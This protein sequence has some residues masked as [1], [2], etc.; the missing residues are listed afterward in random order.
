M[1]K[2]HKELKWI[3]KKILR[4][5]LPEDIIAQQKQGFT[6][7]LKIW[8]RTSLK[9]HIA[10]TLASGTALSLPFE[11]KSGFLAYGEKYLSGA[12]NNLEGLWT[13]YVLIKWKSQL[14]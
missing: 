5:Y 10:D 2:E 1:M 7:P 3:L 13:I 8:A 6:P 14:G 11:H 12:H 4:A 9:N